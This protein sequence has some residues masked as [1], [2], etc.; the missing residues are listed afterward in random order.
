MTLSNLTTELIIQIQFVLF[1]Q[2]PDNL[3]TED[4]STT[5]LPVILTADVKRN[6]DLFDRWLETDE[7]RQPFILAGPEGC[8]KE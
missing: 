2:V 3:K 7:N 1:L 4:F 8:G 6:L 5:K